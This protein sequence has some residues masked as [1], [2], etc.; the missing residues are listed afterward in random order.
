MGLNQILKQ[1]RLCCLVALFCFVSVQSGFS[2][3]EPRPPAS[4]YVG[5]DGAASMHG[6]I[7]CSDTTPLPGPGV[8]DI[9]VINQNFL[10][11]CPTI[12]MR[13]DG[14]PFALCTNIID[15]KPVVRL[16]RKK[17]GNQI[18]KLELKAGS[19]LGGVYAYIDNQDRLVMVDGDQQLIRIKALKI[20]FLWFKWWM[21]FVDESISLSEK[22]EEYN[23]SN[24]RDAVVSISAGINGTIWFVTQNGLVGIYDPGALSEDESISILTL[25]DNERVDNSF[26]TTVDGF[27]AIVTNAALYLLKQDEDNKPHILWHYEYDAGSARKPG[28]LSHGSG[29]TPTFFGPDTGMDFVMIT[30]NADSEISLIVLDASDG[31]LIC[32]QPIFTDQINFGT[33]NSAIGIGNTVIV[34]STYGYPYPALPEGA[35]P[36]DPEFADFIGGMIRVDIDGCDDE[37]NCSQC[38]IV[39]ENQIRSAAV[40]KLSTIDE[41]I[42]TFERLSPSGGTD[43]TLFDTYHF[44]VIDLETGTVLNQ[45]RAGSGPFADTLQ[46]AGNVGKN[47]VFWQGNIG[48]IYRIE[49]LTE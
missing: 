33:E 32:R 28:Q 3:F 6:D 12:I 43:T 5:M 45:T 18:A 20:K 31:S 16:L 19:L 26:S 49:P 10:S 17:N 46:M 22:I 24:S 27:A 35:T 7:T 41:L 47:R 14:K 34:A 37:T 11:A 21:L 38:D 25:P 39:W 15:R 40:P 48:G 36:S 9:S 8:Q 4:P 42:Y 2:E 44:T 23:E 1:I 29:A 30:D 13:S